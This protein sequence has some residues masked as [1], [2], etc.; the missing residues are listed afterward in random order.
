VHY[1]TASGTATP[2]VDYITKTGTA[3]IAAGADSTTVVVPVVADGLTET[4]ETFTVTLSAPTGGAT[5]ARST[6][7]ATIIDDDAT[8]AIVSIGEGRAVEGATGTA[9][10]RIPITLTQPSAAPV[11]VL[12][13]SANGS[14]KTGTDYTGVVNRLVT[15]PA[16]ATGAD[17]L[18]TIK[19][20]MT[21]EPDET[22]TLTLT[23]PTGAIVGRATGTYVI[24]NDD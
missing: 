9:I 13:N 12:V 21:V 18:V 11:T 17:V 15:I 23:A 14:A 6:G 5:L 4:N 8:S 1:A 7:T 2:T 19:G 22:F 3:T 16:G 10:V 20:D 24:L